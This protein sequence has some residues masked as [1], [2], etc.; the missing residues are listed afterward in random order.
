MLLSPDYLEKL[1]EAIKEKGSSKI[2]ISIKKAD[3]DYLFELKDKRKFDF[4]TLKS[5]NKEQFIKKITV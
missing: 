1:Y 4:E 3:K 5:L 2:K